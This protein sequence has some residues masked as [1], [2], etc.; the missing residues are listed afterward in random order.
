M[1]HRTPLQSKA[2]HLQKGVEAE[3]AALE[4]LQD[5]G[6]QLIERNFQCRSGEIDLIMQESDSLVFVEVRYRKS[7]QF[8]GAAASI[9]QAKQTKIIKTAQYYLLRYRH[10]P[11]MRFDVIAIEGQSSPNWIKNAF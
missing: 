1:N 8:G 9:T 7:N 11:A 2:Q 5:Q 3:N 10:Q 4:Y 6:L